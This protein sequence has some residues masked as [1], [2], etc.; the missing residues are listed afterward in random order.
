MVRPLP[1]WCCSVLLGAARCCSVLIGA[2]RCYPVPPRAAPCYPPTCPLAPR[3]QGLPALCCPVLPGAALCRPL[4]CSPAPRWCV[5]ITLVGVWQPRLAQDGIPRVIRLCEHSKAP[6]R[7][8]VQVVGDSFHRLDDQ[9]I[10]ANLDDMPPFPQ[11][12]EQF[13]LLSFRL[14]EASSEHP[15][16][17]RWKDASG[18][19]LM[20]DVFTQERFYK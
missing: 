17:K 13:L 6:A 19:V 3:W 9:P 8:S 7:A 12:W 2:A 14:R 16:A 18:T 10:D 11:V 1:A 4:V 20:H 5:N 15:F